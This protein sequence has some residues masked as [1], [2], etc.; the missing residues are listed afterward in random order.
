MLL[1]LKTNDS[2]G[3]SDS[4]TNGFDAAFLGTF[5]QHK[6]SNMASTC[7]VPTPAIRNLQKTHFPDE[8]VIGIAN[9]VAL[10][11]EKNGIDSIE[12]V[13]TP[14]ALRDFMDEIRD[15]KAQVSFA[16]VEDKDALHQLEKIF[17]IKV[18][19]GKLTG[20]ASALSEDNV[21]LFS[22]L[23]TDLA[24]NGV[25]NGNNTAR[26]RLDTYIKYLTDARKSRTTASDNQNLLATSRLVYLA[27]RAIKE[28]E[29]Y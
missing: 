29:H 25:Q 4:F 12:F 19:D 8:S 2:I 27:Q 10:Y 20:S 11:Q 9:L 16:E 13:P 26:V 24:N 1:C 17:G 6:S 21:R 28:K 7:I 18:R 15:T 23:V 14:D 22:A 3:T 5:V